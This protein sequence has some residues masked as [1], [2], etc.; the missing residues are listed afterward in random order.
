MIDFSISEL[1]PHDDNN[2]LSA[3]TEK[4]GYVPNIYRLLS[5]VPNVLQALHGLNESLEQSSFTSAETEVIALT[6]SV[7]NECPYCVAG[8]SSFA[9]QSGVDLASVEA[10]RSGGYAIQP[11]LHAVG[12]MTRHLLEQRGTLDTG[13]LRLFLNAGFKSSQILEILIGIAGKTITNFASKISRV[14]LDG[15]FVDQAW[16]PS[17]QL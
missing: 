3:L 17:Q 14:P 13:E 1:E 12:K 8:H 2:V 15:S 16:S 9:L 4:L 7:Y 5:R 10:I 11:R 6:T